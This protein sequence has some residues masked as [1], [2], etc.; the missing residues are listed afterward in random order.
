MVQHL[1]SSVSGNTPLEE[2][3]MATIRVLLVDDSNT[4]LEQLTE[5]L[6]AYPQIQIAGIANTGEEAIAQVEALRPDLVLMDVTMPVMN[7]LEATR[8][9]KAQ[10]NAPYVVLLSLHEIVGNG[11]AA[12]IG[13]DG[14]VAKPE[15]TV[16]MP[17]MLRALF[18]DLL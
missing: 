13:A 18:L 11:A 12:A 5:W 8:R 4:F 10:P 16:Q 14:F 3:P 1:S 9:I 6:A 15:L 2:M 17:P 7:G